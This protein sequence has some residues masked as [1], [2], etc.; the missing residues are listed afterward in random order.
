MGREKESCCGE[1]THPAPKFRVANGGNRV[2][3]QATKPGEHECG[4]CGWVYP[5]GLGEAQI[6][7]PLLTQQ[8]FG[9]SMEEEQS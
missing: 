2:R 4:K 3:V 7:T 6:K 1:P 8:I 9:H 5:A